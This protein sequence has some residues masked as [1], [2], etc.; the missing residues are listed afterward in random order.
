MSDSEAR[1]QIRQLA[2]LP[3]YL[4]DLRR[5]IVTCDNSKSFGATCIGI[6]NGVLMIISRRTFVAKV[7]CSGFLCGLANHAVASGPPE[8]RRIALNGYDPVAYFEDGGPAKGTSEFWFSFDDVI[9]LFRSA[10][11]RAKFA[12]DPE[13]YAPQYEGYCAGGVSKG[14]R[15]EPDPEAWIIANGKLFVFEFK[16]RVP[17]FRKDIDGVAAR[18]NA[19]W[20]T[21]RR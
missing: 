7:A 21:L 16:E 10:E 20:P 18:A 1:L 14:Y 17:D 9:Y 5:T 13:R 19:N 2:G 6:E 8:G 11:H 3:A 4:R 15:T 12:A